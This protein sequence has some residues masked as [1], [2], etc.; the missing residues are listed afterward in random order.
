MNYVDSVFNMLGIKPY[1]KFNIIVPETKAE[2][3]LRMDENLMTW[4]YSETAD[5]WTTESMWFRKILLGHVRIVKPLTVKEQ[6]AIEYAKAC[7]CKWI[8]KD[9]DGFIYSYKEKPT[10][11]FGGQGDNIWRCELPNEEID[12]GMQLYVPIS[13][14]SWQDPEPYYVG[15]EEA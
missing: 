10:K 12:Y 8:A 11:H 6:A 15:G 13:F 2:Y 7:G 9:E 1:E 4:Q 14:L 5:N 3:T